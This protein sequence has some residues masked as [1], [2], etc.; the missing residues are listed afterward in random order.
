MQGT[1]TMIFQLREPNEIGMT[2]L[3]LFSGQLWR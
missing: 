1:T 3:S 2:H